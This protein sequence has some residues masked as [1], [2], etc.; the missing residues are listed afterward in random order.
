MDKN[1]IIKLI[2][3]DIFPSLEEIENNY[4][5]GIT[6]IFQGLSIFYN[7]KDLLINKKVIYLNQPVQKPT[8]VISL[9]QSA[10]I[11][12]TALLTVKQGKQWVTFS[13]ETKKKYPQ[14]NLAH[15]LMD[16]IKI[17]ISCFIIYNNKENYNNMNIINNFRNNTKFELSKR[18]IKKNN[19]LVKKN[20]KQIYPKN[21]NENKSNNK[22]KNN[23]S[24]EH[25][26]INSYNYNGRDSLLVKEKDKKLN[27]NKSKKDNFIKN[28]NAFSTIGKENRKL[29]L[30]SSL[31]FSNKFIHNCMPNVEQTKMYSTIRQKFKNY[32]RTINSANDNN[33]LNHNNV[34]EFELEPKIEIK[35][36]HNL[37][38]KNKTKSEF[39]INVV[40]K[41][42]KSCN[43]LNVVKD[44]NI[45]KNKYDVDVNRF[46]NNNESK[47]QIAINNTVIRK[48][49]ISNDT[50]NT[51]NDKDNLNLDRNNIY[52]MSFI[53]TKSYY[54]KRNDLLNSF[55]K[56]ENNNNIKSNFITEKK[57]SKDMSDLNFNSFNNTALFNNKQNDVM[58]SSNVSEQHN[59]NITLENDNF[60]KLKEDFLLL[61]NND[62]VKNIKEDLLNLEIEL[63]VEKT[64]ELTREYHF[65]LFDKLLEYQIERNKC[66]INLSNYTQINKLY[67][68]L[69]SIKLNKEIK[70]K[71]INEN[72]KFFIKQNN[73]I[74]NTNKNEINLYNILLNYNS[75]NKI[76]NKKKLKNILN[77]ILNK[78]NIKNKIIDN[79]KHSKKIMNYIDKNKSIESQP[80]IRTRII[81]K[82]QQTKFNNNNLNLTNSYVWDNGTDKID[83]NIN[84]VY[85]KTHIFSPVI[86]IKDFNN[87]NTIFHIK[88][89]FNNSL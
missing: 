73:N 20:S 44:K 30:N 85:V 26:L 4:K 56:D 32:N 33:R 88:N 2:L 76:E 70:K 43:G 68:K 83:N 64:T 41:K 58:I 66:N 55:Q 31:S 54:H 39:K 61:Y 59:D 45:I 11:L 7:L 84:D 46:K 25:F 1:I 62:Y 16:C 72:N 35:E 53:N 9:V 12:A 38:K 81:P 34:K 50:T 82:N 15:S 67:N 14:S 52:N 19:G 24:H 8:L 51:T 60:N 10:N 13:Y 87:S 48:K 49:I 40:H 17:N 65:Q 29:D 47:K 37:F 57:N 78:K 18:D 75:N 74:F 71:N 89:H 22:H 42:Q 27:I 79:N 63:F 3:E 86:R 5:E 36:E 69:Q 80:G 21:N 28:F 23:N 6:I 77:I